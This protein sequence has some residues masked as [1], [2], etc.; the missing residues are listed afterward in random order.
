MMKR[1]FSLLV[2]GL[3]MVAAFSVWAE[4][5]PVVNDSAGILDGTSVERVASL[6]RQL[7]EALDVRLRVI[8]KHFL[9]GAQAAAYAQEAREGYPEADKL[10]LLAMIVGEER[11]AVSIGQ[12]AQALISQDTASN[13]LASAFRQPY[14]NRDYDLALDGFLRQLTSQLEN[15]SGKTIGG[16]AANEDV[17]RLP[18]TTS[19]P[20][21]G[22]FRERE[23]AIDNARRYEE[24]S[25]D[26][27]KGRSGLS[28]WQIALIGFVLYKIFGKNPRSGR[29]RGCGP[30]GWIFGTWGLSKFFGFRK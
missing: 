1:I 5:S 6:D 8:T 25:Q 20:L 4:A 16:A 24:E 30:L 17:I 9:G 18:S 26:A 14:L 15:A 7:Q 19:D 11:Y 22:F 23:R 10:I 12:S 3:F 29:K 2:A 21:D 27:Q 28:L 13:I